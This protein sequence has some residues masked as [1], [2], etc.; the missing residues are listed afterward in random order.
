MSAGLIS[1][2]SAGLECA[3][4]A[5]LLEQYPQRRAQCE[6][7]V[8]GEHTGGGGGGAEVQGP[9][10]TGA[11]LE[12]VDRLLVDTVHCTARLL[13]VSPSEVVAAA[14]RETTTIFQRILVAL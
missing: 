3:I 9:Q 14:A 5:S 6:A 8:S 12:E 7:A 4:S 11:W 2:V 10:I 1:A 13:K